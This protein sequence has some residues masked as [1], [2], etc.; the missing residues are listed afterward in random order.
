MIRKCLK[1]WCLLSSV[2]VLQRS[3][4]MSASSH[5]IHGPNFWI[6]HFT[7]VDHHSERLASCLSKGNCE[8]LSTVDWKMVHRVLFQISE[9]WARN[10]SWTPKSRIPQGQTWVPH[11]WIKCPQECPQSQALSFAH[12]ETRKN[13]QIFHHP[14]FFRKNISSQIVSSN[15]VTGSLEL[16]SNR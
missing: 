1:S 12:F 11:W 9:V 16:G 3:A 14:C 5:L 6:S 7:E 13:P 8:G 10:E 4:D 15:S 2:P